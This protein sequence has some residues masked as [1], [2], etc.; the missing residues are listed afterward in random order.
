ML[1]IQFRWREIEVEAIGEEQEQLDSSQRI[2]QVC[3][4]E[5]NVEVGAQIGNVWNL[6]HFSNGLQHAISKHIRMCLL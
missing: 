5:I 4:V 1:A 6:G 3:F 2:Q